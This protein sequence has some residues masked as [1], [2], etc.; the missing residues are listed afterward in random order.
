M[1]STTLGGHQNLVYIVNEFQGNTPTFGTLKRYDAATGRKTELIKIP[2]VSIYDAQISNDGQWMLFLARSATEEKLQL[3]RVNGQDLQTLY[4]D[5]QNYIGDVV[6]SPNQALV[7]FSNEQTA[8]LY[9]LNMQNGNVQVEV[10]HINLVNAMWLDDIHVYLTP[11]APD[12]PPSSIYM[13]DL[14]RGAN[15]P[16]SDLTVVFQQSS[17]SFKYPCVDYSS[18]KGPT[19]F[20]S[21]CSATFFPH[22]SGLGKQQGPS[23]IAKQAPSDTAFHTFFTNSSLAVTVV[24]AVPSDTLLLLVENY[25]EDGSVATSQNGVWKIRMDGS[26]LAR[27]TMQPA[28]YTTSFCEFTRTPW[29]NGSR[30]GNLYAFELDNNQSQSLLIG[31]LRGGVPGTIASLADGT[32]LNIV[33]WMV[34]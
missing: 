31:S 32:K 18:S 27:L 23:T 28:G 14:G 12:T 25:S 2:D 7:L 16:F 10:S 13:L 29:A 34:M 20:L 3:I 17:A 8:E 15:Q 9:L 4:C 33:G 5:T 26:G 21:Q 19:V 1:S 6:W 30:D 22:S 24:R 11:A